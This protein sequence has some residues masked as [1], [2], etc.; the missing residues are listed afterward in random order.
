MKTY[1]DNPQIGNVRHSVSF[2]DGTKTHPDGSPFFDLRIFTRQR[3][4][5][6]FVRQL[7]RA[8]YAPTP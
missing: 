3:D 6:A 4:K 1:R 8:G 5:E 2:H 7:T